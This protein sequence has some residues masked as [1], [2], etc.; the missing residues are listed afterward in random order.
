MSSIP[1]L[2]CRVQTRT[3]FGALTWTRSALGE[4][5][6]QLLMALTLIPHPPRQLT[7]MALG[8]FNKP[9]P[10][11][12]TISDGHDTIVD[13][14]RVAGSNNDAL[15]FVGITAQQANEFMSVNNDGYNTV[16]SWDGGSIKLLG[17]QYSS[18]D[19]IHDITYA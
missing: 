11:R 15:K 2:S 4:R 10:F 6:R 18:L 12:M 8:S 3:V 5:S 13:Y 7:P 1:R 17:V 16:I 14:S 19:Q 9:K